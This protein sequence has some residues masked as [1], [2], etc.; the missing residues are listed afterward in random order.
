M[1]PS[2]LAHVVV[3]LLHKLWTL[4]ISSCIGS[5][6]T[7]HTGQACHHL[8]IHAKSSVLPCAFISLPLQASPLSPTVKVGLTKDLPIVVEYVIGEMG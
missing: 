8:R 5:E 3:V 7:M 4:N 1:L 2:A 6:D